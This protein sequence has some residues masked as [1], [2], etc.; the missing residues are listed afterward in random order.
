MREKTKK[1]K[2]MAQ[3]ILGGFITVVFAVSISVICAPQLL[4]FPHKA[5]IGSTTVY[6]ES[7]IDTGQMTKV[8][9]RSD[10]LLAVSGLY[11]SPIGTRLFLTN[12]GWRWQLLA[13]NTHMAFALTR[14]TSI[15]IADAAIFN[16]ADPAQDLIFNGVDDSTEASAALLRTNERTCSYSVISG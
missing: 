8:L 1:P 4:A 14:P 10:N 2:V 3:R 7:P 5:T 11:H 12:G 6:A 9:R 15:M 16:R 13:L